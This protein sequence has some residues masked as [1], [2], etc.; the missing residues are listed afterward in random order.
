MKATS[1]NYPGAAFLMSAGF[2]CI[3]LTLAICL[4]LSLRGERFS[5]VVKAEGGDHVN[6]DVEYDR[7]PAYDTVIVSRI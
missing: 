3:S 4:H 2:S 7:P 6:E 5:E 1:D